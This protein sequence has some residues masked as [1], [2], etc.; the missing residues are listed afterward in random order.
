MTRS[1]KILRAVLQHGYRSRGAIWNRVSRL[2][3]VR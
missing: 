1:A 2:L 3:V